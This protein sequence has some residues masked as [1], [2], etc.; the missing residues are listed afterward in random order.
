MTRRVL[1]D[2]GPLVAILSA[3]DQYHDRCVGQLQS[4]APPL[5]T[6]WPVVTEAAWLLRSRPKAIKSLLDG[7]HTGFLELLPMDQH[8]VAEIAKRL[9]R[10]AVSGVQLADIC[11]V[12]LAQRESIRTLFTL[13]RRD[14][15]IIRPKG[16]RA[17]TL[18][19][20]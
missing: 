18:L 3:S 15:Q 13:D 5:L 11:L 12:H 7:F 17:L 14:F 6:C 16:N 19:P 10:Y 2:T 8:D 1:V 4:L 20:E 9:E